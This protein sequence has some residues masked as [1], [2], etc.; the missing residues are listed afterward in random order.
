M[1]TSD[2]A[3]LKHRHPYAGITAVLATM[4]GKE[5]VIAPAFEDVLGMR[6]VV[7]PGIDTDALGT[8]TGE[9]PRDGTMLEVAIRK[10]RI[11]MKIAGHSIGIAS[12]G[13]FARHPQMPVLP[14]GI[15]LM[16][17]VDDER[18]I[19]VSESLISLSTNFSHVAVSAVSEAED[20]IAAAGFPDHAMVVKTN[21]EPGT[22]T[23]KGIVEID[24]LRLAIDAAAAL[25][26][27]GLARL[28]TDMRAHC[29]PTRMSAIG[30]LAGR[31]A[32]RLVKL[33]PRCN[34]PGYDVI[35][36]RRGLPCGT[37]G[38][39][40]ELVAAEILRCNACTFEERSSPGHGL[41][42]AST[43]HCPE[44]NP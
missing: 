35:E 44:C 8:F 37:C 11:G 21:S 18:G 36:V 6:I 30:E 29:N 1:D 43:L 22:C 10:A 9:V 34:A 19:V 25:S 2:P 28:E 39:P 7:P 26:M 15:E 42:F 14:A 40:T 16:V 20:F 23:G 3:E 17:L 33:C 31:L 4:H 5:R 32:R 41:T 27:D 12:E 13:T 24:S 38:T